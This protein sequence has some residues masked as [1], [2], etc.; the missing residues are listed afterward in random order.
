MIML[1]FTKHNIFKITST[2]IA[3][4][5][6]VNSIAYGIDLSEKTSL[7]LPLKIAET[8]KSEAMKVIK[9]QPDRRGFLKQGGA[10][11][12]GIFVM[13][14]QSIS[15]FL[16]E[17]REVHTEVALG[18]VIKNILFDLKYPEYVHDELIKTI[19]S[20]F[21]VTGFDDLYKE[22]IK[23]KDSGEKDWQGDFLRKIV[24]VIREDRSKGFGLDR[25]LEKLITGL[26]EEDIFKKGFDKTAKDFKKCLS[27]TLYLIIY[28]RLAGINAKAASMHRHILPFIEK[29]DRIIFSDPGLDRVWAFN[30]KDYYDRLP[31]NFVALKEKYRKRETLEEVIKA[32]NEMLGLDESS[33]MRRQ[34]NMSSWEAY[35]YVQLME[36]YSI[37]SAI[38]CN[39]GWFYFRDMD[40]AEKAIELLEKGIDV[41]PNYAPNFSFLAHIYL[42]EGDSD[43]AMEYAEK[44]RDIDPYYAFTYYALADCYKAKGD[45]ISAMKYCKIAL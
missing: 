36:G 5:F 13:P 41:D 34:E 39:L 2:I 12:S 30:E 37:T 18:S 27:I 32:Y 3:V 45:L 23:A 35:P 28:L 20:S 38:Y 19:I 24:D 1:N 4:V 29:D 40:N 31:K 44:A 17:K 11:M 16:S 8:R 26:S 25:V 14:E 42:K 15:Y 6:F 10:F 33:L 21:K 22:A 43:R 7:R 9:K